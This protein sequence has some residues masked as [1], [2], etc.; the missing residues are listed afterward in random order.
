LVS[1]REKFD[2]FLR[3]VLET[4]G[5]EGVVECLGFLFS[6]FV[7]TRD[8]LVIAANDEFVKLVEYPR[9]ELYGMRALDLIAVDERAAMEARFSKDVTKPYD[10]K[11]LPKSQK[12]KYVTVSPRIILVDAEKFRF[13]ELV[14][15][16]IQKE[17]SI[18]LQENED[19]FHSVFEQAAV[20]IARVSPAG[21]FLEVNQKLCDILGY[22]KE[23]LIEKTFQEMTHPDDLESDLELLQQTIDNKRSTYNMEKRFFHKKGSVIW[24]NLT[25]SL[26]RSPSGE[27]K[28]FVSVIEDISSRKEMERELILQANHD[29]LTG[30]G[31][32]RTL[33][34]ELEKE[35]GRAAR[36]SRP[37]SLLMI[38][39]D[40]FK[41]VNDEYGH[42]A[43]DKVLVELAK[44]F[45]LAIRMADTAG[46]YG[47]EEFLILLPELEHKQA[48]L[49]AERIRLEVESHAIRA[50]GKVINVSVSIGVSSYP[51]HGVEAEKLIQA[52]DNAMYKAKNNGRNQTASAD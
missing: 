22:G 36:Y 26:I 16:T 23:E 30:L 24:V 52:S 46:R 11:L 14:D 38:D 6:A 1:I 44:I 35:V 51:E 10:L 19:K 3:D 32:R 48:V 2:Q 17:E 45:E 42:Q 39:I 27:P 20:G 15:I 40:H 28:Y 9:T 31:N 29:P 43:G 25:V 41:R 47:G 50:E 21:T 34:E 12:I 13:A 8:G 33:A 4:D 5:P 37:L 7:I 18:T 49:L